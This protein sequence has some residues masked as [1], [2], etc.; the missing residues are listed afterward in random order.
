MDEAGWELA[1]PVQR[2]SGVIPR[3][4]RRSLP[5]V[6]DQGDEELRRAPGPAAGGPHELADVVHLFRPAGFEPGNVQI[7]PGVAVLSWRLSLG[8]FR[9]IVGSAVELDQADFE[10]ALKPGSILEFWSPFDP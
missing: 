5:P 2:R 10:A 6:V 3:G 8:H 9:A 4:F 1:S 7:P